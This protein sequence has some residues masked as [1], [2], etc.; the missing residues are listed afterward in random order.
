MIMRPSLK[1]WHMPADDDDIVIRI[2]LQANKKKVEDYLFTLVQTPAPLAPAASLARFLH[3]FLTT[4]YLATKLGF[5]AQKWS[6][7]E[8]VFSASI[9]LL[10]WLVVKRVEMQSRCKETV[11]FF[12]NLN[13]Q[14]L[15]QKE[16]H[17]Q[18]A[19]TRSPRLLSPGWSLLL[20]C[21]FWPANSSPF[22]PLF[23]NSDQ[24][25]LTLDG[26]TLGSEPNTSPTL[27]LFLTITTGISSNVF[28][29]MIY[30]IYQDSVMIFPL[31]SFFLCQNG[32]H[33]VCVCTSESH[34]VIK[35][36]PYLLSFCTEWAYCSL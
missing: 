4:A 19:R 36:R 21:C 27:S 26:H 13:C 23:P 24:V 34:K 17:G 28:F 6:K 12:I 3:P 10:N 2:I 7:R 32:E 9:A 25:W 15:S 31:S 1:V 5:M 33:Y 18:W 35:K 11:S 16:A 30:L 20:W 22:P 29:F 14:F 8:K